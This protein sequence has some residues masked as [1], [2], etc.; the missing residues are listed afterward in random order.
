MTVGQAASNSNHNALRIMNGEQ[1]QP[2]QYHEYQATPKTMPLCMTLSPTVRANFEDYLSH[3]DTE[4]PLGNSTATLAGSGSQE[5][6]DNPTHEGYTIDE[7]WEAI[8]ADF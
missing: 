1:Q 3:S 2:S 8:M 5:L 7:L 6:V 4:C